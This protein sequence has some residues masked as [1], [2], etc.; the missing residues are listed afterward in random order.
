MTISNKN[1]SST[2]NVKPSIKSLKHDHKKVKELF[3]EFEE[4]HANKG[5]NDQKA[6]LV[7]RIC[8][9]L[10][11]HTQLEEKIVYPIA[12]EELNDMDLMDEADVEHA[13]AKKLIK[14]LLT[15]DPDDSHYDAKVTV[16]KEYVEHHVKE[17]EKYMLPELEKSDIA[18][19]ELVEE[20]LKFKEKH[21]TKEETEA[22]MS[23]SS[24]KDST[25]KSSATKTSK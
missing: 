10:T 22:T 5:S 15:M 13:G 3:A 17:E 25:S 24:T 8:K 18:G 6:E 16:L 4:L 9:Q 21:A 23:R 1:D 19:E 7:N 2:N 20:V 14:E 12:R 11:I